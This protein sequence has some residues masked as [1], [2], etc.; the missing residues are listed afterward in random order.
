MSR[1]KIP[2]GRRPNQPR[3]VN[4]EVPA[5]PLAA[6]NPDIGSI[7]PCMETA[8]NSDK[9]GADLPVAEH[10]S[11]RIKVGLYANTCRAAHITGRII[12]HRSRTQADADGW[13]Q[14][15]EGQK[16]HRTITALTKDTHLNKEVVGVRIARRVSALALCGSACLILARTYS[17]N[18]DYPTDND[19]SL[20]ERINMENRSRESIGAMAKC[21]YD[22]AILILCLNRQDIQGISPF[23]CHFLYQAWWECVRMNRDR[24]SPAVKNQQS[25]IARPLRALQ[26][27]WKIVGKQNVV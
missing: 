12:E 27:R 21:G 2:L 1:I 15:E 22:W 25:L 18:A 26:H 16:L 10:I 14:L 13:S 23:C 24:Q 3:H 9:L 8:W 19:N 20:L 7:L 6:P 4:L 17:S 5:I 11:D